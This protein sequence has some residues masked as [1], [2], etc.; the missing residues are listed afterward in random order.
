MPFLQEFDNFPT[1]NFF[2]ALGNGDLFMGLIRWL[3]EEE[4]LIELRPRPQTN[5]PV[6]LS[7]QQGRAL[8]VLTVGLLPLSVLLSGTVVW[9]KRR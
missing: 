7:R 5:R 2:D 4:S 8:M 1:N 6:V 9:W 3:G